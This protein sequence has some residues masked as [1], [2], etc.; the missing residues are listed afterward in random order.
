MNVCRL[1]LC[2]FAYLKFHYSPTI[3]YIKVN[4]VCVYVGVVQNLI[5]VIP[6]FSS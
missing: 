6:S 2:I 4:S 5:L 3:V 1:L